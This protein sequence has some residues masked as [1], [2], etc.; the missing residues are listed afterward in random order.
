MDA[1]LIESK[2]LE[3]YIFSIGVNSY[4]GINANFYIKTYKEYETIEK[5]SKLVIGGRKGE[6]FCQ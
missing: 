1:A 3:I 6:N 2:R 5:R 4:G